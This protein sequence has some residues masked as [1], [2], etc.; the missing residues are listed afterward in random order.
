MNDSLGHLAG[1][2]LLREVARAMEAIVRHDDLVAR[3]GGDEFVVILPQTGKQQ[4]LIMAEKLLELMRAA[5]F[6]SDDN[7]EIHLTA[8]FGVATFPQDGSS[9]TS[10]LRAADI[11]MYDAKEAGRNCVKGYEPPASA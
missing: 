11:A 7:Q 10:L 3:Y 5:T 6:F 9:R 4:A 8:S 1:D 2:E